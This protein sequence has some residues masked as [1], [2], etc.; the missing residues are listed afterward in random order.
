MLQIVLVLG[1]YFLFPLSVTL[2][3]VHL[4]TFSIIVKI[5]LF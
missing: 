2:V 3:G 5:M 4:F 1:E